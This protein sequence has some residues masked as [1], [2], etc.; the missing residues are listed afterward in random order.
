MELRVIPISA[1]SIFAVACAIALAGILVSPAVPS[2]P[3][4]VGKAI[5]ASVTSV[6][7]A[8]LPPICALAT[9][10][11]GILA[12]TW[13]RVVRVRDRAAGPVLLPLRR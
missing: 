9:I 11:L 4:V 13:E 7:L 6:V 1:R 3:T 5:H 2:L 8:V 10:V 12:L